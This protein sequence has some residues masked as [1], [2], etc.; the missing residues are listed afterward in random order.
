MA[1]IVALRPIDREIAENEAM[2]AD[3]RL[4]GDDDRVA[5][6]ELEQFLLAED[7]AAGRWSRNDQ[8]PY[9]PEDLGIVEDHPPLRRAA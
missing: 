4:R 3:A 1:S 6:L 8:D 5:E 2:L 7:L 9:E